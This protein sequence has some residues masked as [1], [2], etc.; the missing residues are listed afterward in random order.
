MASGSLERW[1]NVIGGAF[2]AL[3]IAALADHNGIIRALIGAGVVYAALTLYRLLWGDLRRKRVDG[4]GRDIPD[5][6]G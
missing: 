4:S 2:G 3:S 1:Q 5:T 6:L